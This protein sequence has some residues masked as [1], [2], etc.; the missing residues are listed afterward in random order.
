MDKKAKIIITGAS[1]LLGQNT[2]LLLKEKGYHNIVAIDKH[3]GNMEILKRLNPDI[4]AVEADLAEPGSW[5]THFKGG[6]VLLQLH[7][8]VTSLHL[9]EFERNNIT[10]TKNVLAAAKEYGIPYVV[11]ISSTVVVS[12]ADDYY[13][14]TKKAQD[15]VVA[16][17]GIK[18]CVLRPALM[19]GW[20][21]KKHLG[22]L[23]RF[24]GKTPV[25]P[26][27]GKGE[28][29]RQ[30]LY[31][32][33]MARVVVAA[34]EQQPDGAAYNI[35]GREDIYYGDIIRKIKKAKGYKTLILNIPYGLF[36]FLLK[37]YAVFFKNPPFT[38]QQLAALT[39]G[40]YFES[41]PW[42]DIFG[43]E[44]TPFETALAETFNH[45]EYAD[46]VLKP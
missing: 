27:P 29:L 3:A 25:F 1:G 33:D 19:F 21:D 8:Q 5:Q 26:V 39:A 24:M 16:E 35:V 7:A 17:S 2:A 12:V 15:V 20:F 34:M 9:E 31:A 6:A 11:H 37:A 40:D 44:S 42:W 41:D 10:A 28:Y 38:S 22:W 46:I 45:G 23:S 13:T 14:N 43:V 18:H 32:R 36:D 30:P 4:E